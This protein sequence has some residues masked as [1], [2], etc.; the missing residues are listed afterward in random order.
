[1]GTKRGSGLAAAGSLPRPLEIFAFGAVQRFLGFLGGQT[2]P[3][4][5]KL[6]CSVE[7][8]GRDVVALALQG[9]QIRGFGVVHR[10]ASLSFS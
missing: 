10:M 2:L 3:L 4:L 5:A 8:A 9:H 7:L 1:M 6:A